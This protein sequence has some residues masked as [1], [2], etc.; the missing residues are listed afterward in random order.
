MSAPSDQEL[1]QASINGDSSA[2]RLLVER[3]ESQIAATVIGMLGPGS[4]ADDVGQEAFIRFYNSMSNFRG[5]SALSTYLTRIAINLSLNAIKRRQR[6][7]K[8]HLPLEQAHNQT[9]DPPDYD[10]K[11]RKQQ[12]H[13]ALQAL[14]AKHRAVVVLRYLKGYSTWQTAEILDIPQGTVLSRLARAQEKLKKVLEPY[15]GEYNAI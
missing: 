12:V 15:M 2:F 3:Y 4:E 11:E 1:V 6:M 14:D 7:E 13:R 9:G 8:V 5:D 10:A